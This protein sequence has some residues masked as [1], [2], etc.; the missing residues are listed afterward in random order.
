VKE[1]IPMFATEEQSSDIAERKLWLA[2][3]ER[4]LKDY[5][6]FF[7]RWERYLHIQNY[8][9]KK[10]LWKEHS[11]EFKAKTMVEFNKLHDFIFSNDAKPFNLIYITDTLYDNDIAEKLREVATEQINHHLADQENKGKFLDIVKAI[12]EKLN[13]FEKPTTKNTHKFKRFRVE[14]L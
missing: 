8:N 4:A 1:L 14:S 12:R 7:E 10:K 6:F 11:P 13:N 9:N 3:I 5:S 2:V